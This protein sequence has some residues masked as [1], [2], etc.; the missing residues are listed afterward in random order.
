MERNTFVWRSRPLFE[1]RN[2][3]LDGWMALTAQRE[4][5]RLAAYEAV[6]Q[7]AATAL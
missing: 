2:V 4:C 7:L 5:F 6:R 1:S 3:E